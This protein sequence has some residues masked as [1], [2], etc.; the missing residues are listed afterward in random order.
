MPVVVLE[1]EKFL[2]RKQKE[3]ERQSENGVV[4][5]SFDFAH[6]IIVLCVRRRKKGIGEAGGIL[7]G[8]DGIPLRECGSC[9]G[10]QR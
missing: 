7:A 2:E 8:Y 5:R 10:F 4:D 3:Y 9:A 6:W 1:H